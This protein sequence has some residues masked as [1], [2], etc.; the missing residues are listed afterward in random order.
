MD[1]EITNRKVKTM[2]KGTKKRFFLA[3]HSA[4]HEYKTY[5]LPSLARVFADAAPAWTDGTALEMQLEY[6]DGE[7]VV[8]IRQIRP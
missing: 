3:T 2:L 4:S 1:G 5:R 7:K 8:T 6:I